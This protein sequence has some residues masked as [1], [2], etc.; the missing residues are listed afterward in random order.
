[1]RQTESSQVASADLRD[2]EHKQT[3]RAIQG[4]Q[5]GRKEEERVKEENRSVNGRRRGSER[6]G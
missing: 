6:K 3:A 1:M 4:S 5:R 2:P